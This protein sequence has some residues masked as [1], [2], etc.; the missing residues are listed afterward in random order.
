MIDVLTGI[1]GRFS[2]HRGTDEIFGDIVFIVH[3]TAT[4][5]VAMRLT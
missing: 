4:A 1:T 5:T 3:V 2:C